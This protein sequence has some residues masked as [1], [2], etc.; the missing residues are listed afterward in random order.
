MSEEKQARSVMG[1]VVSDKADKTVT[2]L[3]ERRVAHPLYKKFMKRSTKVRAH[4][5]NNE[6]REGDLVRI[7][8]SRPRSKTKSWELTGVVERPD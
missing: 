7:Q 2:V 6:G 5:E 3:I 4:D 8:E 1:R